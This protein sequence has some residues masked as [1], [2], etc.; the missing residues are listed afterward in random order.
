MKWLWIAPAIAVVALVV[1]FGNRSSANRAKANHLM[2][3]VAGE[4]SCLG[5]ADCLVILI[6]PWCEFCKASE[7]LIK[8]LL[9]ENGTQT[10]YRVNLVVSADE[11]AA[12]EKHAKPF[13]SG[14]FVDRKTA[15][16]ES[17]ELRSFPVWAYFD[18]SGKQRH[19]TSGAYRDKNNLLRHLHMDQ[20]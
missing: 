18:K 5:T 12:L 15:L 11:P 19:R 16:A 13:G 6:A 8:S 3:V 1:L 9:A 10:K 17:M 2:P 4:V 14:T 7:P 20:L